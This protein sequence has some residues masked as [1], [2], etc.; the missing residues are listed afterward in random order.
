[1][2]TRKKNTKIFYFL[3]NADKLKRKFSIR[4]AECETMNKTDT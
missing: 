1:M 4:K 3:H 2:D